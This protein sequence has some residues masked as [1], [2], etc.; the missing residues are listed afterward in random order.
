MLG[1]PLPAGGCCNSDAVRSRPW[2]Q[3]DALNARTKWKTR[4]QRSQCNVEDRRC[5]EYDDERESERLCGESLGRRVRDMSESTRL[6]VMYCRNAEPKDPSSANF[7]MFQHRS[8][9]ASRRNPQC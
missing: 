2:D 1:L 6:K 4:C 3:S 7:Y 8:P 5:P 9:M